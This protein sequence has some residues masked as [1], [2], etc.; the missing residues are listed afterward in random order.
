MMLIVDTQEQLYH[1]HLVTGHPCA[2]Q[3]SQY[4]RILISRMHILTPAGTS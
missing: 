4:T 2:F 1:G 3:D